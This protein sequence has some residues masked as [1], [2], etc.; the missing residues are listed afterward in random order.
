MW[1]TTIVLTLVALAV[2]G[3]GAFVYGASRWQRKTKDVRARLEAARMPITPATYDA[4]E[5]ENL[6][7][8][9][10]RYFRVVLRDGQA[11]V[12]GVRLSQEGQFRQKDREDGW[13]AFKATQ[14]FTTRPPGFD[15]D[16]RIRMAPGMT[17]FVRDAYVAAEGI[18]HAEVLGLVTV[19]DVHGGPTAAKGELLRYLAEATW[20]PTALLPSQGVRWDAMD[21]SAALA[22]LTH[23]TTTVSLEFRFDPEGLI[24]SFKAA[25]RPRGEI[26]GVSESAPWHGRF[27][28][29]EVRDGMRIPLE[30]EVAWQLPA[31]LFPYWRGRI[32]EIGYEFA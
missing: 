5:I 17:A 8:P 4:R 7:S 11:I 22:T 19:A 18:L 27:W 2:C 32:R 23:G 31:G 25:S 20:F 13:L 30:G 28:A 1:L 3:A 24:T 21:D 10:R 12:G 14:V 29:Y 15:W 6:P 16:A 9:V 26:D